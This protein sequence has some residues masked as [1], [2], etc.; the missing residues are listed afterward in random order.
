MKQEGSINRS[1]QGKDNVNL[2]P[3]EN[4]FKTSNP[5]SVVLFDAN[6]HGWGREKHLEM[7]DIIRTYKPIFS[8]G[9]EIGDATKNSLSWE[10]EMRDYGEI[11]D[12]TKMRIIR[13][14]EAQHMVEILFTPLTNLEQIKKHQQLLEQ[15]SSSDQLDK[16]ISTKNKAYNLITGVKDLC[17]CVGPHF[18]QEPLINL[19]YEGVTTIS[20]AE[21]DFGPQGDEEEILPMVAEGVDRITDGLSAINNLQESIKIP[22]LKQTLFDP[23]FIT[24]VEKELKIIVPFDKADP[25]KEDTHNGIWTNYAY[26]YLNEILEK[27]IKPYLL[28]IGA[29]LEFAKRIRDEKWGKVSFD[30]NKPYGYTEGWN[31]ERK[32]KG[33][34]CNDSTSDTPI[35]I[36]SGA[37]TSGKSFNMKADLLIR[38]AAQSLGYAPLKEGNL[39]LYKNFVY[40]DRQST[41]S[42][43]DLSAFMREIENW[44]TVIPYLNQNTRLYVDEG[45][46]TTSPQDQARLLFKTASYANKKGGS[47]MLATHNDTI[48]GIAENDPNMKIYHLETE[49]GDKGELI[50]HFKLK[51]GRS[52]SFAF[53]VA[54]AGNYPENILT[55][56]ESYLKQDGLTPTISFPLNFP[57]VENFFPDER[58]RM[59]K[60]LRSLESLFP[61][62]PAN[63]IFH[64]FSQDPDF[65]MNT[66]LKNLTVDK[67][68]FKFTIHDSAELNDALAKM[69]LWNSGLKSSEILE[70]QKMFDELTQNGNYL[71]IHEAIENA[72]TL[73][74]T[75]STI[76]DAT[77]EGINKR[78]NPFDEKEDPKKQDKPRKEESTYFSYRDLQAAIAFLRIQQKLLGNDPSFMNLF[79]SLTSF[80]SA[81]KI[82]NKKLNEENTGENILD[83]KLLTNEEKAAFEQ[84]VKQLK[85]INKFLPAVPL[86]DINFESIKEELMVLEEHKRG[87]AKP[88]EEKKKDLS[89]MFWNIGKIT[90]LMIGGI[91]YALRKISNDLEKTQNLIAKLKAID[92]IYLHQ[93]ANILVQ[94]ISKDRAILK[95]E[96]V[97]EAKAIG[98]TLSDIPMLSQLNH[99][100]RGK[101]SFSAFDFTDA[102]AR[103]T[104]FQNTLRNLD[105]ICL[106]AGIIQSEKLAPVNLNETGEIKLSNMFSIFK[107]KEKEIKNSISFDPKE[108]RVQLLTGPNGCG[109]TFYEK[110]AV[111]S[112]LMSLATGYSPAESASIPVLDSVVYLD[113]VVQKQDS[114]LSA[115]SQEIEYWKVLLPLL[116]SKR[117]VFAAVDEAFSTTSPVYQAAFTYAAISEFLKN[118]HFLMLATHNHDL[119]TKLQNIKTPLV[120][121]Y[122]FRFSIENGKINYEYAIKEGH[123]N[124]Y[125]TEVARTMNLPEEIVGSD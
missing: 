33:Q 82:K 59:K 6:H 77:K 106:F 69:V 26:D 20:T 117:A 71:N 122:H 111:A 1:D 115:F 43:N 109:K 53:A 44:K 72:G 95:G 78:L 57:K 41:D 9:S 116:K 39:P 98:E 68:T 85:T 52:E 100:S 89:G 36:L 93:A 35:T 13:S 24:E 92:S 27:K 112:L 99:L 37:N 45:Y 38:L 97:P 119:V 8:H 83:S 60:Q 48:L 19:Y 96:V 84:Y 88:D 94:E 110:G 125:A 18:S 75:L 74:L 107:Q 29:T 22:Y 42:D 32:K 56:I 91:P 63:P 61:D 55:E 49:F 80:S 73:E 2:Y 79:E 66:F 50:R 105:A 5:A 25:K 64:L 101:K 40:L 16:L 86:K 76:I 108:E 62:A 65:S 67:D 102:E 10:T 7:Q 81:S 23:Q 4:I 46:S 17:A 121:P 114:E 70:R 103:N 31:M 90:D 14:D 87:K 123:E 104:P 51:P 58:E 54:K 30:S 3:L 21:Y 34:V 118:G 124:S 120:N 11:G 113:R 12:S 15:L 28:R 47:V